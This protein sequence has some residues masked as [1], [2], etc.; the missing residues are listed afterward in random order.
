MWNETDDNVRN[1][2]TE[3]KNEEDEEFKEDISVIKMTNES[4]ISK[5]KKEELLIK[6]F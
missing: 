5:D 2:D 6:R 1:L 3:Q 4:K